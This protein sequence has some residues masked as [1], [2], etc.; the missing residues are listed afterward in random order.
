MDKP[1]PMETQKPQRSGSSAPW[2]KAE[3]PRSWPELQASDGKAAAGVQVLW[4]A[5]GFQSLVA[6]Q[7]VKYPMEDKPSIGDFLPGWLTE[8]ALLRVPP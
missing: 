7:H 3:G 5:A 1:N 2:E 8:V 4:Y 6:T